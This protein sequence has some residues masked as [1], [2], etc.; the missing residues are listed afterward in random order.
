MDAGSRFAAKEH[1]PIL[2][3]LA[4]LIKQASEHL[5]WQEYLSAESFA[6]E[7]RD[8]ALSELGNKHPAYAYV[9]EELGSIYET[10]GKIIE[11]R[12]ALTEA[13]EILEPIL[14]NNHPDTLGLFGRLYLMYR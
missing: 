10:Q 4:Q 12:Y 11:A 1:C 3:K 7:A 8:L 9:L 14:G 5:R 2:S 6:L 13:L